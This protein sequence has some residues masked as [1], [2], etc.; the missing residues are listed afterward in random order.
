[1]VRVADCHTGVL[2]LNP[3]GPKDF[4]LGITSDVKDVV[5]ALSLHSTSSTR[6]FYLYCVRS[7]KLFTDDSWYAKHNL[8]SRSIW[9]QV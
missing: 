3:G 4:P 7:S 5:E 2:G 9:H 8:L 6:F 1:M